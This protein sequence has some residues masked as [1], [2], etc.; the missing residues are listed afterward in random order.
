MDNFYVIS[1]ILIEKCSFQVSCQFNAKSRV[2][3]QVT[4]GGQH[5]SMQSTCLPPWSISV[6][7]PHFFEH[8]TSSCNLCLVF[9]TYQ[10]VATACI[11][12][13][14]KKSNLYQP[15]WN[16][17]AESPNDD[18]S[19]SRNSHSA[20]FIVPTAH[21]KARTQCCNWT[22][23]NTLQFKW[24]NNHSRAISVAAKYTLFFCFSDWNCTTCFVIFM[25]ESKNDRVFLF[26]SGYWSAGG[27]MFRI[28][29]EIITLVALSW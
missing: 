25:V 3:N 12:F 21:A 4:L 19:H 16:N 20:R 15:R 24:K 13:S 5:W 22:K 28:N 17:N 10:K 26:G 29:T 6:F 18:H 7:K 23:L 2:I 27:D 9:K 14:H 1:G 8:S 11:K